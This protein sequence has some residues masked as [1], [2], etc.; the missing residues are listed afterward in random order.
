MGPAPCRSGADRPSFSQC[1][2]RYQQPVELERRYFLTQVV[3]SLA[4]GGWQGLRGSSGQ[5]GIRSC[6]RASMI[7]GSWHR[8]NR[9]CSEAEGSIHVISA[10][11]KMC[12]SFFHQLVT[13]M[14]LSS[15][16]RSWSSAFLPVLPL[17]ARPLPASP[18]GNAKCFPYVPS[19]KI[20]ESMRLLFSYYK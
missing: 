6:G 15:L 3:S 4:R 11:E 5:G 10:S 7:R 1:A 19:L 20:H 12:A 9:A 13:A 17:V 8:L 18:E 14:S 16:Q 2:L